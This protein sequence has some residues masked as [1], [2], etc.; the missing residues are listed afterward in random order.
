MIFTDYIFTSH[1]T[2]WLFILVTV[3]GI[4]AAFAGLVNWLQKNCLFRLSNEIETTNLNRYMRIMFHSSL[5]LFTQKDSYTLLSQS[6]KSR[7]ISNLL[8]ND[9]LSL[10]FDTFRAIFYLIVMLWIDVTMSLIVIAL[11]AGNIIL[12]KVISFVRN[13]SST[14][15]DDR[16]EV[17]ELTAQGERIYALGI[18][19][20]ETFKSTVAEPILFDRI[21]GEKTATINAGR[22]DDF[23]E[24]YSPIEDM[25]EVFFMNLLLMISALRIMDRSFSI[26]TY[27]EFQAYAAAFFYPLSGILSI[28][29]QLKEFE[30]KLTGFFKK[31]EDNNEEKSIKVKRALLNGKRK[32]DGYIEFRDVTFGYEENMPIIKNFDLKINPGQ[33]VAIIGKSGVGKTTLLKLLQGL[34]EPNSGEVTIDG[35]PAVEI[36]RK[37]FKNSIG[38]ANQ[39]P[40]FFSASIRENITMWDADLTE[41]DLYN[42]TRTACIHRY[43]SSLD[44]AYEYQL[45]ENGNNISGGQRQ[46]LEIARALIYN[47]SILLFDEATSSIDPTNRERIQEAIKKRRC[48]C[49]MVTHVL[50]QITKYDEIIILGK[51]EIIARGKHDELMESSSF[52]KS[53]FEA[54]RS[55]VKK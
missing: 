16:P 33:M 12:S 45:T 29:T 19:N 32:L 5:R 53:L 50:S 2:G 6:E 37:V 28:T 23:E 20:I 21:L 10:L 47:P 9:V 4:T 52:Y 31:L 38:C 36:D 15:D 26:G 24:A 44:S 25:S 1:N 14:E 13:M 22:D 30:E 41:S 42:S 3:M 35:I 18:Q 8:T 55:T 43:I 46:K 34:Y 48:A 11:V 7:N 27:L 17:D 39:E 40:A 54:E 49:L 51:A